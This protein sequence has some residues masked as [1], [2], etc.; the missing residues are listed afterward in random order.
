MKVA[1]RRMDRLIQACGFKGRQN[2]DEGKHASRIA[3]NRNKT[4]VEAPLLLP[5]KKN[6]ACN[7]VHYY[8]RKVKEP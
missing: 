1:G 5:S 7:R 2:K 8:L 3:G 6:L 4:M